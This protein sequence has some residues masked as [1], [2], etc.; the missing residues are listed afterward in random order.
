M[1]EFLFLFRGGD[2]DTLQKSSEAWRAHMQKWM[3]WMK[4]LAEQ[5]Y[6]IGA[7]PLDQTGRKIKGSKKLVSQDPFIEGKQMVTGYL[8]CKAG[9]Y[10]DAV[11]IAK[12]CPILEFEDGEVEVRQVQELRL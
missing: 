1:R 9:S 12:V 8:I 4:G 11:E 3:D 6:L 2:G 7:Q 5:G 10:D